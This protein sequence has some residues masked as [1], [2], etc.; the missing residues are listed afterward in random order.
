[1]D[2][3]IIIVCLTDLSG[4]V[5][6]TRELGH[7][8]SLPEIDRFRA[9]TGAL[10][11][12]AHGKTIKGKG[13]GDIIVFKSPDQA[14]R[15]AAL[16]QAY[17]Q[18]HRAL[19]TTRLNVRISM[20]SGVARVGDVDIDG[21][22]INFASRLE[23]IAQPGQVVINDVLANSLPTIWGRDKFERL[24]T[25][26]GKHPIK[27]GD[28]PEQD[29]YE[30]RWPEFNLSPEDSLAG[31]VFGH[32]RTANVD[33]SNLSVGDLAKPGTIIW[34]AVPRDVVTA[35]HRA[36]TEIIRLLALLGWQV[37]LLIEDCDGGGE[38]PRSRSDAFQTR[39]QDYLARGHLH[40]STI[41][42][43][44]DY[45]KV[46]HDDHEE[47]QALFKEATA[48]LTH[49]QMHSINKKDYDDAYA[50]QVIGNSPTLKF[51]TPALSIAVVIH[52]AEKVDNKV[53]VVSGADE[54]R[55]W[56]GS[57]SISNARAKMG[58]I[59]HPVLNQDP[60]NQAFQS[61]TGP[62]WD[63]EGALVQNMT[64][65]GT[66]LAWWITNALAFVPAFPRDYVE[67]GNGKFPAD[68]P[69]R[70]QIP[71]KMEASAIARAVWPLLA[72]TA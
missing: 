33:I 2:N 15:F 1:M 72:P 44:S 39:L 71:E 6:Q 65:A 29:L 35:I 64:A 42:R 68:W 63:S 5:Q 47:V 34:P 25:S 20:F 43:L 37:H 60:D 14:V 48:K 53:I 51:L 36:Q 27:G 54:R 13:D 49:Q 19:R 70:E 11:E 59:M 28:P 24:V 45:Y 16:L 23:N 50:A 46:S 62:I 66:N 31:L 4:S 8:R 10:A 3:E 17:Y 30:I 38:F 56:T 12:A 61:A 69:N 7:E 58:A 26:I 9:T 18:E 22:A 40:L 55:Q 21:S 57:Y 41:S 32:L 52:L 67:I